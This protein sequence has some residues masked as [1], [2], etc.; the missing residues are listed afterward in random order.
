MSPLLH[1]RSTQQGSL[2]QPRNRKSPCAVSPCRSAN[3]TYLDIFRLSYRVYRNGTGNSATNRRVKAI[4]APSVSLVW[5][6][7]GIVNRR[8]S[9]RSDTERPRKQTGATMNLF[10]KFEAG[11][12][13]AQFLAKYGTEAHRTR[14]KMAAEQ[15]ALTDE[16]ARSGCS[17]PLR[18]ARTCLCL[19]GRGA[20]TVRRSARSSSALRKPRPRLPLA[21]STATNTPMCRPRFRSTAGTAFRWSCSSPK[22]VPRSPDTVSRIARACLPA[23]L[24][25]Q[26]T[27]EGC[28]TGFVKGADPTR[29]A[30][31]VQDWLNR[32]RAACSG[33]CAPSSRGS[34]ACTTIKR[35]GHVG[36]GRAVVTLHARPDGGRGA[37]FLPWLA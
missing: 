30:P 4:P 27:G 21:T 29:S 20:A 32:V 7:R 5:V 6:L 11:L 22:T 12:P 23:I 24:V 31:S 8:V 25:S 26:L 28:A 37:A 2:S 16:Q 1:V 17:A 9:A 19:P 35:A 13:L 10:P 34:A 36:R 15:T 18:D 14:W 3:G 33:Y